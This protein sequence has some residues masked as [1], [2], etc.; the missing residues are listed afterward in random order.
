MK[1][2]TKWPPRSRH[3]HLCLNCQGNNNP[4]LSYYN[5]V[6]SVSTE[7]GRKWETVRIPR[8]QF[9]PYALRR[10]CA[11]T[12]SVPLPSQGWSVP[13]NLR[14]QGSSV[15]V[16]LPSVFPQKSPVCS[17]SVTRVVSA[18]DT[19]VG[20]PPKHSFRFG[21]EVCRCP[22][23]FRRASVET[24]SFRVRPKFLSCYPFVFGWDSCRN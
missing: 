14:S 24:F 7:A 12:I 6:H 4:A 10:T 16:Y 18:H 3:Q 15:T 23:V 17:V 20:L 5:R 8:S 11:K 13:V 19:S 22:L 21:P 1:P 2:C 9:V